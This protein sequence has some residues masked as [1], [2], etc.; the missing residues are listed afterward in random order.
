MNIHELIDRLPLHPVD[1]F[2][3]GLNKQATEEA[4]FLYEIHQLHHGFYESQVWIFN[5]IEE[6]VT[7]LPAIVFNDIVV[8]WENYSED[9]EYN[10][11]YTNDYLFFESLV[12]R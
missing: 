12:D 8:N 3:I 5:T 9:E 10:Y 7:F 6:F 4:F 11:D 1:A 2:R